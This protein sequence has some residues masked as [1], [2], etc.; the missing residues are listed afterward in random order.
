MAQTFRSGQLRKLP[1]GSGRC[2][3]TRPPPA[4][5]ERPSI[6]ATRALR[7]LIARSLT[8]RCF[9]ARVV[10]VRAPAIAR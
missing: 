7:R 2:M 4:R 10:I 1:V 6:R 9:A 8:R 3:R 5:I